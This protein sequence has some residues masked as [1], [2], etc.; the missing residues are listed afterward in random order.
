MKIPTTI[1]WLKK[2]QEDMRSA[3]FESVEKTQAENIIS[4]IWCKEAIDAL[5]KQIPKRPYAL[6]DD[7]YGVMKICPI[8]SWRVIDDLTTFCIHCGQSIDWSDDE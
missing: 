3:E 6:E 2:M 8:C 1:E 7:T 4:E 5:E